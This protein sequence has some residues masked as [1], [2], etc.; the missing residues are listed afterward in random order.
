MSGNMVSSDGGASNSIPQTLILVDA[1]ED[2]VW[3]PDSKYSFA[4][5]NYEVLY[6]CDFDIGYTGGIHYKRMNLED[7]DYYDEAAAANIRAIVTN[8]Y[9]YVSLEQMK[10]N[11]SSMV[12]GVLTSLLPN[13]RIVFLCNVLIRR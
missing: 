13:E 8:S 12:G 5:S 10:K 2:Y 3:S 1:T 4:A 6:C 7:S 11:V 9:P